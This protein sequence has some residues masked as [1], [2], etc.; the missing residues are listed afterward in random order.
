VTYFQWLRSLKVGDTVS[1]Y[2]GSVRYPDSI[3]T[4]APETMI[5]IGK[6]RGKMNFNRR[7]GTLSGK[8]PMGHLYR[9]G[10]RD[11][12]PPRLGER[13]PGKVIALNELRSEAE[14]PLLDQYRGCSWPISNLH[15]NMLA[16]PTVYMLWRGPKLLYIGSTIQPF[17][18]IRT[19]R[20]RFDQTAVTTIACSSEAKARELE[21]KLLIELLPEQNTV[22][23]VPQEL[24]A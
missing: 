11:E 8:K 5:T 23:L 4:S 1:V 14:V 2:C 6:Y 21:S 20:S 9:I 12:V 18:R 3:V 10:R 15:K 16:G 17:N 19:H 24:T 7:D 22:A 13:E